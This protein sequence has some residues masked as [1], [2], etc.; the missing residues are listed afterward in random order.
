MFLERK[1]LT[2]LLSEQRLGRRIQ[3]ADDFRYLLYIGTGIFGSAGIHDCRH[4]MI[5][6]ECLHLGV[7]L[8]HNAIGVLYGLIQ[9]CDKLLVI[10]IHMQ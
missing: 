9:R 2:E 10:R 3:I 8:A 7:V 1:I 4:P 6:C 5:E